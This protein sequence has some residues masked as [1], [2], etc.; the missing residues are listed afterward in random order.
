MEALKFKP[1]CPG[2]KRNMMD[3]MFKLNP[4]DVSEDCLNL[5]VYSPSVP[6]EKTP[7]TISNAEQLIYGKTNMVVCRMLILIAGQLLRL[8][9]YDHRF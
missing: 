1:Q 5:N 2:Q 7:I 3:E 6:G 8:S 4:P 9:Q